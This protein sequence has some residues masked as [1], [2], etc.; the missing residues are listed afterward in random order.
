[1]AWSLGGGREPGGSQGR[2]WHWPRMPRPLKTSP[3]SG[4]GSSPLQRVPQGLLWPFLPPIRLDSDSSQLGTP[5][6][7]T[8]RA[9]TPPRGPRG[10]PL[11]GTGHCPHRMAQTELLYGVPPG[12]GHAVSVGAVSCLL[13]P[14]ASP[15]RQTGRLCLSSS[16]EDGLLRNRASLLTCP[17]KVLFLQK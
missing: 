15:A 4:S 12:R 3:L 14:P 5:I 8:D 13:S 6:Q 16:R 10:L 1:M 2:L 11:S 7:G 17:N 9:P